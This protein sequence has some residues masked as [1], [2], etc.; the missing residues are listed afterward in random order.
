M[1]RLFRYV[2]KSTAL[3]SMWLYLLPKIRHESKEK[4][5]S[6]F[7]FK[8]PAI[9][10]ANH[11]SFMDFILIIFLF[12]FRYV[13]CVV[14]KTLYESS[15]FIH[16]VLKNLGAIKVDRFSFSMDFF[17][18]STEHLRKGGVLLIFPEGKLSTDG[19]ILPFKSSAAL[20]AVRTGVD[21]IPIYHTPK[22][23]F[24]KSVKVMVG[25]RINL[26]EMCS[27]KNPGEEELV[28]LTLHLENKMKELQVLCEE[29]GGV[30]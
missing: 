4:R 13:R 18:E 17:Y 28:R 12:A 11:T 2:F 23:G 6:T 7:A 27:D 21:I 20:M 22:Y 24:M 15:K 8:G 1:K 26:S 9:V 3:W 19:K 25:D 29:G 16:F 14:G 5:Q 10:V 30:K